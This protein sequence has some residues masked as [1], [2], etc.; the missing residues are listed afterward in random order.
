V[1]AEQHFDQRKMLV[2]HEEFVLN[3]MRANPTSKPAF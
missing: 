2:A 1:Y 3:T